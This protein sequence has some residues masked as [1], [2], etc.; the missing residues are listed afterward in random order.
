[1]LRDWLAQL[2]SSQRPSHIYQLPKEE[3]LEGNSPRLEAEEVKSCAAGWDVVR[4]GGNIAVLGA[5]CRVGRGVRWT[6]NIAVL[7][8]GRAHGEV[9]SRGLTC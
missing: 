5:G 2:L 6:T 1:M 3:P 9:L 7:R 4:R 8:A